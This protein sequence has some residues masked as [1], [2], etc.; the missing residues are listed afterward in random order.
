M[1]RTSNSARAAKSPL[2]PAT[3]PK[4]P[5]LVFGAH[6][7]DIEFGCGALIASEA[8]AGRAAHFVV[9]SRGEAGTNGNPA[10]RTAEAKAAAAILGATIE[11]VDLGGDAHFEVTVAR[12]IALARI[13]RRVRPAVVLAPTLVENQHPDH[14]KLGQMVRDATRLAR[15]GGLRELRSLPSH[16]IAQLYYFAISPDAEPGDITPVLIDTSELAVV[17][18]WTDAMQAH[19]SQMKTRDYVELQ[20]MRARMLGLRAGVECAVAIFPSAPLLVQSLA[21]VERGARHF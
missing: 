12:T 3:A 2:T 20:L 4:P 11:F 7:D 19:A 18:R 5:L 1:K 16:A 17:Q 14:A 8:H 15:F 9:C 13:I 21:Q 6:P 10:E